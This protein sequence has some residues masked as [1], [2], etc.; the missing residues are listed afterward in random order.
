MN[1]LNTILRK[2][3]IS[4]A[5]LL[6][7]GFAA[8]GNAEELKNYNPYTV[9]GHQLRSEL[10]TQSPFGDDAPMRMGATL[11]QEVVPCRFVSTLEKDGYPAPW[12]G[13]AFEA[14]ESRTYFPIGT[15]VAGDWTNPCSEVV[16]S[17]AIAVALRIIATKPDGSGMVFVGAASG[18]YPAV[19]FID[20]KDAQREADVALVAQSFRVEP[21]E[22]TDLVIDII[23]YFILDPNANG[24]VGPKGDRGD[25]GE[26]GEQGLQGEKGEK[27]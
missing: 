21:N 3:I 10:I 12:G 4:A 14:H 22:A 7:A 23:G 18:T 25:K 17:R 15:L 11:F 6:I 26:R 20:G 13:K 2:S 24:I 5:I 16:D 27:G 9:V 1:T 19:H 8:N